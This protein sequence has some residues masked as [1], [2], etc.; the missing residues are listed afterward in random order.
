MGLTDQSSALFR[1]SVAVWASWD[2]SG[3]RL[4]SPDAC[5]WGDPGLEW[6]GLPWL[7]DSNL[8][9]PPG[10]L[11]GWPLRFHKEKQS[12]CETERPEASRGASQILFWLLLHVCRRYFSRALILAATC[13]GLGLT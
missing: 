4:C 8:L 3:R 11:L 6:A 2:S 12:V 10:R 9:R 7:L 1:N 5:S 13:Q